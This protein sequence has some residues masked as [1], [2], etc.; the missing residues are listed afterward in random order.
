VP[1]VLSSIEETFFEKSVSLY[2][3]LSER[4]TARRPYRQSPY[5]T[6]LL[7]NGSKTGIHLLYQFSPPPSVKKPTLPAGNNAKPK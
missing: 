2:F 4:D 6:A 3:A 7:L 1:A 5:L